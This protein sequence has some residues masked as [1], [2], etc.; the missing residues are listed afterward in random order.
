MLSQVLQL[1][2]IEE[3]KLGGWSR[4]LPQ[5]AC[6]ELKNLEQGTV[7]EMKLC[8]GGDKQV[9]TGFCLHSAVLNGESRVLLS[10]TKAPYR[11][12]VR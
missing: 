3:G 10:R 5:Q 11:G 4:V 6:V 1:Y 7:Q 9:K 2:S 8:R 12:G